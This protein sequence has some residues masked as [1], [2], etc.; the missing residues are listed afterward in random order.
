MALGLLFAM[1]SLPFSVLSYT[2]TKREIISCKSP[3]S[4]GEKTQRKVNNSKTHHA[5]ISQRK[6]RSPDWENTDATPSKMPSFII[7]LKTTKKSRNY[8]F[9]N[10]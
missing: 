1:A 10:L 3:T 9:K 6:E 2:P 8:H 5:E 4:S 7:N